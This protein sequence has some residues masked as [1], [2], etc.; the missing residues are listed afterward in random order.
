L[1]G[2]AIDGGETRLWHP[3]GEFQFIFIRRSQA[4]FPAVALILSVEARRLSVTNIL[5]EHRELRRSE[6]NAI[7]CEFYLRFLHP[8]VLE[9]G[10]VADLSAD[11]RTRDEH[12]ARASAEV[13]R[14]PSN[15]DDPHTA[16]DSVTLTE[17]Q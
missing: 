15:I 16:S 13:E 5:T 3:P 1:S 10:L 17:K 2:G 9:F 4:E 14:P 8:A 6:Y 11:G 12:F 7:F